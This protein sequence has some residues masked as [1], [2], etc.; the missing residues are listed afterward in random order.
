MQEGFYHSLPLHRISDVDNS[1]YH[2]IFRVILD[3]L[4]LGTVLLRA[5]VGGVGEF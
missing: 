4:S 1:I 5:A 3:Q 2:P